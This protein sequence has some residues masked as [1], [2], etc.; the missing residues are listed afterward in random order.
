MNSNDNCVS[1]VHSRTPLTS[2]LHFIWWRL[3]SAVPRRACQGE[4]EAE[5]ARGFLEPLGGWGRVSS[6]VPHHRCLMPK[7]NSVSAL[8]TA[9]SAAQ[10]AAGQ[11][12]SGE[13]IINLMFSSLLGWVDRIGWVRLPCRICLCNL[14]LLWGQAF[15]F[16]ITLNLFLLIVT[17][18]RGRDQQLQICHPP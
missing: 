3:H 10:A 18:E 9:V 1:F 11:L 6:A 13:T 8:A 17:L 15:K 12:A 2:R 16:T 7:S 4:R 5:R 14:F